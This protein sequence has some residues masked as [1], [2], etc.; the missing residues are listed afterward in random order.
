MQDPYERWTD[1]AT[2]TAP[3]GQQLL[4]MYDFV[5]IGGTCGEGSL[6]TLEVLAS[7]P[8]QPVGTLDSEGESVI[9]TVALGTVD[10][11]WRVGIGITDEVR[12]EAEHTCVVYFVSGSSDGGVGFGTHFQMGSTGED[13]L[14]TVDSLDDARAYMEA[15]EYR[16]IVEILRSFETA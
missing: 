5:D 8:A 4:A 12:L 16:T 15:Q 6:Q 11:R 10:D 9:A 14:W 7:E 3:N 13:A 1:S 2:L